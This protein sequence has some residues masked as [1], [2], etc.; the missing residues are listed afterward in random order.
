MMLLSA[1]MDCPDDEECEFNE[2]GKALLD[3]ASLKGWG[4]MKQWLDDSGTFAKYFGHRPKVDKYGDPQHNTVA[5]TPEM[6]PIQGR[7]PLNELNNAL[8]ATTLARINDEMKSGVKMSKHDVMLRYTIY[9]SFDLLEDVSDMMVEGM[10]EFMEVVWSFFDESHTQE[11]TTKVAAKS[12]AKRMTAALVP[13]MFNDVDKFLLDMDNANLWSTNAEGFTEQLKKNIPLNVP[14]LRRYVTENNPQFY[15]K[16]PFQ[17]EWT[18]WQ[19]Y[20]TTQ[21]EPGDLEQFGLDTGKYILNDNGR[22]TVKS[23]NGEVESIKRNALSRGK[24][25]YLNNGYVNT[26]RF[27][28]SAYER[29]IQASNINQLLDAGKKEEALDL[30]RDKA[31]AVQ[32]SSEFINYKQQ[33]MVKKENSNDN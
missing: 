13:K 18:D 3:V 21:K 30:M 9:S 2:F 20:L 15:E 10:S 7:I 23:P 19:L 22:V 8:A 25:D 4:A 33:Q 14:F 28:E 11:R 32:N 26:Q 29:A 12:V 16:T 31:K 5:I 1:M 27:F 17:Y 6:G 24:G